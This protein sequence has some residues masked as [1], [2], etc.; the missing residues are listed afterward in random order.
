MNTPDGEN[1]SPAATP[2]AAAAARDAR[3]DTGN[4]SRMSQLLDDFDPEEI[5]EMYRDAKREGKLNLVKMFFDA[6][7]KEGKKDIVLKGLGDS[8]AIEEYVSDALKDLWGPDERVELYW[9]AKKK[10]NNEVAKRIR[11]TLPK[12]Q[13]KAVIKKELF[14]SPGPSRLLATTPPTTKLSAAKTSPLFGSGRSSLKTTPTTHVKPISTLPYSTEDWGNVSS[15]S[16]DA[17]SANG[18]DVYRTPQKVLP[19]ISTTA[20]SGSKR[21]RSFDFASLM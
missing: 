16:S 3:C 18:A 12:E 15:I 2:V 7:P 19:C 6:L 13:K 4:V 9:D 20:L 17:C 10:G 8:P 14:N 21:K 11:D 5:A 1:Q